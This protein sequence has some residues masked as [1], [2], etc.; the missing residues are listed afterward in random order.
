MKVKIAAHYGFCGNNGLFGVSGALKIAT[1]TAQNNPAP[2]YILGEL[3]H[4]H[5]VTKQLKQDFN[6]TTVNNLSDIPP[7]SIM[8][9]KSHGLPPQTIEEAKQRNLTI[10]DATCPMVQKVHLLVRKLAAQGK[11]IIYLASDLQHEEALGV[12]GE[13]PDHITLVTLADLPSLT[14]ADPAHTIVLTQTTLSLLETAAALDE[15]KNRYSAITIHP[16]ICPA[17]TDRQKAMMDLARETDLI[18]VVGGN[19]SSNTHRLAE[20]A[21][22]VAPEKKVYLIDSVA[23][24][25]KEWFSSLSPSAVVGLSSGASTPDSVFQAVVKK[26]ESLHV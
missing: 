10:V 4:N 1:Q 6:I 11:K 16:H 22:Q 20:T 15:L 18:I 21:R 17:T 12:L 13:A 3:V 8:I 14:L 26:I 2:V 19:N 23:D 24:L 5:H 9:I 25:Q 7:N